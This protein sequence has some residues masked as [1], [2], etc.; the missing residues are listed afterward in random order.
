MLDG[1]GRMCLAALLADYSGV[2][3]FSSSAPEVYGETC[4]AWDVDGVEL[5]DEES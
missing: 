3:I 5:D 2:V 4:R 1:R